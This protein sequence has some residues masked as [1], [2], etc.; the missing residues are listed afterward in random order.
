MKPAKLARALCAAFQPDGTC[1]LREPADLHGYSLPPPDWLTPSD[2]TDHAR[3]ATA[4]NRKT[5]SL[6]HAGRRYDFYFC[7]ACFARIACQGRLAETIE[8]QMTIMPVLCDTCAEKAIPN[9]TTACRLATR[10]P[11]PTF[12]HAILPL[13]NHPGPKDDP[14]LPK[15]VAQAADNYFGLLGRRKPR[16]Q[17]LPTCP[18][19]SPRAKGHSLCPK[20]SA[21]HKR[22]NARKRA[23]KARQISP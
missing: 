6:R 19:G 10:D 8:G 11:C 14:N 7:P 5:F 21:A 18:C 1:I 20:C 17:T 4:Q 16:H 13:A 15:R 2:F 23:Q 3:Q 9:H 12:E 22:Q